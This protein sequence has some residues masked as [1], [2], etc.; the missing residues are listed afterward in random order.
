LPQNKKKYLQHKMDC[1]KKAQLKT[2]ND[3][4]AHGK[5]CIKSGH[6]IKFFFSRSHLAPK[7]FK[8]VANTKK[9]VASFLKKKKVLLRDFEELDPPES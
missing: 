7:Y 1:A 8:V 4:V 3:Y 5:I 6:E 2:V 9:L